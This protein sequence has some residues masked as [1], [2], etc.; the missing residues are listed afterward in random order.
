MPDLTG[1]LLILYAG[2]VVLFHLLPAAGVVV[3]IWRWHCRCREAC[4][5]EHER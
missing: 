1:L 2:H 3:A 5:D 4:C